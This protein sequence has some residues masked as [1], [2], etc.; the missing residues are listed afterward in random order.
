M[1][2]HEELP[3][4]AVKIPVYNSEST[5]VTLI[6]SILNQTYKNIVIYIYDNFSTD[7]TQSLI[8]SYNQT[9]IIYERN[10]KNLGWNYNFNKCL[11]DSGEDFLLIAHADD[12]YG[13]RFI[14][15]NL[16]AYKNSKCDL[17]FSQGLS[18]RTSE[19][20]ITQFESNELE[21]EVYNHKKLYKQI[22]KKGNFL[23]CPTAFGKMTIISKVIGRFDGLKFGGSADLD[24]WLRFS[25]NN[26]IALIKNT[27]LF[28]HRISSTQ[29]STLDR[30]KSINYFTK[31]LRN[32]Y[33]NKDPS[34]F[35]LNDYILWHEVFHQV[36]FKF[37]VNESDNLLSGFL[38][39]VIK[40]N[41]S[42]IQKIKLSTFIIIVKLINFFP[43]SSRNFLKKIVL[44]KIR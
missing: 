15:C 34:Y 37:Y 32:F 8:E 44:N 6:D 22:C 5:I 1:K 35:E 27:G 4:V 14:E 40:L 33:E 25:L 7:Q 13:N 38:I 39:D 16:Q 26:E 9:N 11:V 36:V 29:L 24:A 17:I 10:K 2:S 42:L 30:K 31:C 23:Y 41:V 28:F 19:P 20:I 21:I 12:V 18:F 43:I 3:L